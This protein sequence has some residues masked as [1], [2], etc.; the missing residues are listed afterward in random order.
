MVLYLC[1][2]VPLPLLQGRCH[3]SSK[4]VDDRILMVDKDR[5]VKVLCPLPH[6]VIKE[7]FREIRKAKRIAP[8]FALD[9]KYTAHSL[10]DWG[11][12][13]SYGVVMIPIGRRRISKVFF[14]GE[15]MPDRKFFS[16]KK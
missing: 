6:D 3:L 5:A 13:L 9:V 7:M 15:K 1:D 8:R 14:P 10:T 2:S 12:S 4:V 11:R 16:K